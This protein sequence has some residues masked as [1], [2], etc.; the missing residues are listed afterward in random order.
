VWSQDNP[1]YAYD[2]ADEVTAITDKVYGN[3]QAF[4]YD[5]LRDCLRMALLFLF[6]SSRPSG[7]R[8]GIQDLLDS[9]FRGNDRIGF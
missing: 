3:N 4:A 7:A 8:A 6:M 1:Y 9:R 5:G 2:A